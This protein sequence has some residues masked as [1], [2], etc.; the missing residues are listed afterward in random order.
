MHRFRQLK[1]YQKALSFSKDVRKITRSFPKE[2]MFVLSAQFR[3]AADSVI[4]NIA[5]G[6]GNHSSREFMRFLV[7][8]LRSGYECIACLDIA[9][10]EEFVKE[11]AY[12][13][14][15]MQID[16]IIAMLYGL[17]KSLLKP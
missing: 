15:F 1:V 5:E 17:Q 12:T 10:E 4:L 7:Y 13:E 2:E 8:A 11:K 16:E 3:R 6:A 9:K 14:L